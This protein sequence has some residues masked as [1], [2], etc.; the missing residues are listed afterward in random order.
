VEAVPDP[1]RAEG[2]VYRLPHVLLFSILAIVSGGNSYRS[3]ATFIDV[4]RQR[5]NRA[6]GLY[7]FTCWSVAGHLGT[8]G[9]LLEARVRSCPYTP[10]PEGDE[11]RPPVWPDYGWVGLRP[12]YVRPN[13]PT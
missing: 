7:S 3:V 4:H 5:L 6:F 10:R 1:R 9:L 2:K 13:R 8:S 11:T 12:P